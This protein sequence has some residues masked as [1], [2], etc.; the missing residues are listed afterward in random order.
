MTEQPAAKV[1]KRPV[2]APALYDDAHIGAIQALFRGDAEPEQQKRGIKWIVEQ[3]AQAD[4][5]TFQPVNGKVQD[6]LEG[7]RSVGLQIRKL[8]KLVIGRAREGDA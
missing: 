7:R 4:E 2:F 8:A 5:Q 1:K 3:A 6:F